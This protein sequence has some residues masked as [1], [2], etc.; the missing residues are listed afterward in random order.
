MQRHYLLY[1]VLSVY[2][3]PVLCRDLAGKNDIDMG[4]E[5]QGVAIH[6]DR[7]E[8]ADPFVELRYR[9][10]ND[11]G[12][13]IWVCQTNGDNPGFEVFLSDDDTKLTIRRRHS[14]WLAEKMWVV[15]EGV[16]RYAEYVRLPAGETR[17][18]S[19]LLALPIHHQGYFDG[20]GLRFSDGAEFSNRSAYAD[21]VTLEIG[22]FTEDPLAA[23][24]ATWGEE[25]KTAKRRFDGHFS[26]GLSRLAVVNEHMRGRDER[27]LFDVEVSGRSLKGERSMRLELGDQQIPCVDMPWKSHKG[28]PSR[29]EMDACTRVEIVYAPSM[30]Q[31]FFPTLRDQS[32]LG[33]EE[34]QHLESEKTILLDDPDLLRLLASDVGREEKYVEYGGICAEIATARVT[35]FRGDQKLTSFAILGDRGIRTADGR[36]F[37]YSYELSSLREITPHILPFEL[38]IQCAAHLRNLWRRLCL[39][40][41]CHSAATSDSVD[42]RTSVLP[43]SDRWCTALALTRQPELLENRDQF[44]KVF[45]CP[46]AGPGECHYAMNPNCGANSPPDMVLLFETKAGWNQHGGPELFAFDNHDPKG[47]CVLLTDGTVQFIRTEEELHALRWR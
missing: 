10:S 18:E 14:F 4:R 47:G 6:C 27:A 43:S 35:C 19:L 17:V 39:Y 30:L 40:S 9:I 26:G 1:A 20:H 41:I 28:R 22:Y 24:F 45:R 33:P 36:C 12:H 31:Y 2:F 23:I 34:K 42:R 21:R 44:A 5:G 8:V 15:E 7:L 32:L 38:R 16:Y 13:D 29:P 46:S 3:L 25:M 11:S 37:A